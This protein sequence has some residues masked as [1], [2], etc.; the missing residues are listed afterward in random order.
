MAPAPVAERRA[1]GADQDPATIPTSEEERRVFQRE[2][3]EER[4]QQRRDSTA[5]PDPEYVPERHDRQI[6]DPRLAQFLEANPD[7]KKFVIN[8]STGEVWGASQFRSGGMDVDYLEEK[9]ARLQERLGE[10]RERIGQRPHAYLEGRQKEVDYGGG[11]GGYGGHHRSHSVPRLTALDRQI[12]RLEKQIDRINDQIDRA[13]AHDAGMDTWQ[14]REAQRKVFNELSVLVRTGRLDASSTYEDFCNLTG[15]QSTWAFAH[16]Q[17]SPQYDAYIQQARERGEELKR[18]QDAEQQAKLMER[19]ELII[20]GIAA[21]ERAGRRLSPNEQQLMFKYH[22]AQHNGTTE[23]FMRTWGGLYPDRGAPTETAPRATTPRRSAYES[24]YNP[25]DEGPTS[26]DSRFVPRNPPGTRQPARSNYDPASFD[27]ASKQA[28][29][30]FEGKVPE[31]LTEKAKKFVLDE[32]RRMDL[33]DDNRQKIVALAG[34]LRNAEYPYD[35]YR[36]P[37]GWKLEALPVPAREP[38]T[39]AGR[40]PADLAPAADRAPASER[41]PAAERRTPSTDAQA[42]LDYANNLLKVGKDKPALDRNTG[43]PLTLIDGSPLLNKDGQPMTG[44][45]ALRY[46]RDELR[47]PPRQQK[48]PADLVYALPEEKYEVPGQQRLSGKYF[49]GVDKRP[50]TEGKP[51][52]LRVKQISDES[53][54]QPAAQPRAKQSE[55]ATPREAARPTEAAPREAAPTRPAT[56]RAP[57]AN[58]SADPFSA[59]PAE[60]TTPEKKQP[61]APT[62]RRPAPQKRSADSADPFSAPAETTGSPAA[63]KPVKMG[64]AAPEE[65][66]APEEPTRR[67][68]ATPVRARSVRLNTS[69]GEEVDPVSQPE[70]IEEREPA[71]RA[72]EERKNRSGPHT[73]R[74]TRG[75]VEN[76]PE[77]QGENG[78]ISMGGSGRP[79]PEYQRAP[80]TDVMVNNVIRQLQEK[81]DPVLFYHSP[82]PGIFSKDPTDPATHSVLSDLRTRLHS[83]ERLN[84]ELKEKLIA[85]LQKQNED[86]KK[87]IEQAGRN[88]TIQ[89]RLKFWEREEMV[90]FIEQPLDYAPRPNPAGLYAKYQH[91][92]S[93]HRLGQLASYIRSQDPEYRAL[94]KEFFETEIATDQE[95][96]KKSREQAVASMYPRSQW[97]KMDPKEKTKLLDAAE[98]KHRLAEIERMKDEALSYYDRARDYMIAALK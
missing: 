73:M 95:K 35:L 11:Y 38:A 56:K 42:L 97:D 72:R 4:R 80:V 2:A 6:V 92:K 75:Q 70:T 45:D 89:E 84:P 23:Q 61:A 58:P 64:G 37:Y 59:A 87:A 77:T 26:T 28:L 25:V 46:L 55:A 98:E 22:E 79:A 43:K 1:R 32:V 36:S 8:L 10:L 71:P 50:G 15:R 40:A 41:A 76:M 68:P 12:L 5:L 85:T 66:M 86:E 48:L 96:G 9:K 20:R 62:E 51:L 82:T 3:A 16:G 19:R 49:L 33:R 21:E 90:R 63:P 30:V 53:A 17:G 44:H 39:P 7:Y 78:P 57:A 52:Q 27:V 29:A 31:P 81:L 94:V 47:K 65:L 91:D 24:A 93:E 34:A 74:P 67:R 18:Q 54:E 14:V 83:V 88:P 69:P 13:E 60:A